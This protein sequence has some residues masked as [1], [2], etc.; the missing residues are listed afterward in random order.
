MV[1][2]CSV[3]LLRSA[4]A[5]RFSVSCMQ[6]LKNSSVPCRLIA[7]QYIPILTIIFTHITQFIPIHLTLPQR[8]TKNIA[9]ALQ[10]ADLRPKRHMF[11]ANNLPK[12]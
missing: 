2:F 10:K 3:L 5:E 1:Q 11:R 7:K 12:P 8:Y 9:K 4:H 6:D